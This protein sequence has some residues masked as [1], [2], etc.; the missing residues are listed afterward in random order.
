LAPTGAAT[1]LRVSL[2]VEMKRSIGLA[3]LAG[4]SGV[5]LGTGLGLLVVAEDLEAGVG[6]EMELRSKKR[7][8]RG[9]VRERVV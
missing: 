2:R 7:R 8:N 9:N 6:V 5:I 4:V 1:E 3:R